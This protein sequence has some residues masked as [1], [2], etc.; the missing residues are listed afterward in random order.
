MHF[1]VGHGLL[2]LIEMPNF[3]TFVKLI[4][5]KLSQSMIRKVLAFD[6][7]VIIYRSLPETRTAHFAHGQHEKLELISQVQ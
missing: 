7:N 3:Y 2:L 4:E 6:Q 5:R 1:C